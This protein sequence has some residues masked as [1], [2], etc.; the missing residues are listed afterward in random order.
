[1][2]HAMSALVAYMA[3]LGPRMNNLTRLGTRMDGLRV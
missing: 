3:R 2:W 1:M